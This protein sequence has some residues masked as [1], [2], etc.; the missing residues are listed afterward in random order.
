MKLFKYLSILTVFCLILAACDDT[1]L[2]YNTDPNNPTEAPN[3]TLLPTAMMSTI[4]NLSGTDPSWISSVWVQHTAGVHAQLRDYDRLAGLDASLVNNNW[5]NLYPTI[6]QNLDIV[7]EQAEEEGNN[8][9]VGIAKVVKAYA[10][11]YAAD[12]W[13]DIPLSES[14]QGIDNLTPVYDS[15]EFVYE[16]ALDL[17][18]NARAALTAETVGTAGSSDLIYGGDADAW[19]RASYALEAKIHNRWSN[20]DPAGSAQRVLDA[21]ASAFQTVDHDLT[22]D[23]FGTGSTEQHPWY[24]EAFDRGHHAFS[25]SMFNAMDPVNDPRLSVFAVERDGEIVPAPN[26][27]AEADQFAASIYSGL[28]SEIISPT[29]PQQLMT[30]GELLFTKAEAHL[31]LDNPAEAHDAYERAV[32]TSLAYHGIEGAEADEFLAQEEIL[33]APGAL[34][35]EH[36]ITQKWISLFP[37]QALEAYTDFRR[38]GYPELTNPMG[39]IPN[40]FPYPQVEIDNNRENVPDVNINTPVWFQN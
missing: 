27:A 12:M 26:G 2:D 31:R 19:I 11:T 37:F 14:N 3:S 6:F 33:P 40:R 36:V 22:F 10:A 39:A 5:N 35:L 15:Q 23:N 30:Y 20:H 13:G 24:Q 8:N 25:E 7:I 28:S 4:V 32:R 21:A 16:Q 29:A 18:S 9:F 17:L 1:M 38:T 34:E